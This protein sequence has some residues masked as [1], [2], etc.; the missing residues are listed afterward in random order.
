MRGRH[1]GNAARNPCPMGT[2]PYLKNNFRELPMTTDLRPVHV[3]APVDPGNR[4]KITAGIIVLLGILA[5]GGYGYSQGMFN[6]SSAVPDSR[7]PQASMPHNA[8]NG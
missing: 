5:L 8:P 4:G 1:D 6:P 3:D 2:L 7:L